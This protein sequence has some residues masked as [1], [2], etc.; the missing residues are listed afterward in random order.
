MKGAMVAVISTQ[1]LMRPQNQR[2][3]STRPRPAP[4]SMMNCQTA[5]MLSIWVEMAKLSPARINTVTRLVIITWL[6]LGL[7]LRNLNQISLTKY[8]A[9]QLSWVESVLI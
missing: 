4:H 3:M 9:P 2:R 1:A 8:D 7:P 5:A 6:S